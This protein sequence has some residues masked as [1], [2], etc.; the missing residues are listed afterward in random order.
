MHGCDRQ[1]RKRRSHQDSLR[2]TDLEVVRS[3]YWFLAD[4]FIVDQNPKCKSVV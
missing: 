2:S 3:Q 4:S 1:L